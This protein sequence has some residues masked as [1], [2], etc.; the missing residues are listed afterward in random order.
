MHHLEF[1]K[2]AKGQRSDLL[3]HLRRIIIYNHFVIY[4]PHKITIKSFYQTV[5]RTDGRTDRHAESRQQN[6]TIH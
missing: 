3:L 6:V 4:R 5:R 2:E 1:T